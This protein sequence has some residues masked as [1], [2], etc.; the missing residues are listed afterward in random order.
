MKWLLVCWLSISASAATAWAQS[1]A[2]TQEEA[3]AAKGHYQ[4]GLQHYEE[5]RYAEAL[6]QFELGRALSN[7]PGFLFNIAR[8]QEHLAAWDAAA[9]AYEAYLPAAGEAEQPELL[10]LIRVLRGRAA[11]TVKRTAAPPPSVQALSLTR[12]ASPPTP[13]YRKGWLWGTLGA[14]VA[15]SAVGVGVGVGVGRQQSVTTLGSVSFQ[16]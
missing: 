15:I 9:D 12:S 2:T 6:H 13:W 11:S 16:Q 7:R 4:L 5:G 3:L 10:H 1:H 14:V 8:C